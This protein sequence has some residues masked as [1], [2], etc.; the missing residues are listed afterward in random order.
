MIESKLFL[1]ADSASIDA[2]TNTLS[3]FHIVEDYHAAAFP[4]VVPRISVLM[5]LFRDPTDP[6]VPE[7]QLLV[8]LGD[9]QLSASPLPVNFGQRLTVRA[10]ADLNGLVI[11]GP[12]VLRFV[13][14]IGA[15][16][17]DSWTINA[18]QVGQPAI[19]LHLGEAPQQEPARPDQ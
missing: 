19:Q 17:V 3:A 10:I 1:C 5:V 7:V 16:V 8:Y 4:V 12:G 2:R 6:A 14:G 9:Q 18:N 13:V 11:P 15:Q